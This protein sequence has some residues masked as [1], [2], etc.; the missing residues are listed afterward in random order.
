MIWNLLSF[1]TR[2]PGP[3][4]GMPS[5]GCSFGWAAAAGGGLELQDPMANQAS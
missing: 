3:A 1:L 4:C 2:G 5:T